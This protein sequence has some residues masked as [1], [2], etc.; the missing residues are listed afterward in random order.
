M[1]A[2]LALLSLATWVGCTQQRVARPSISISDSGPFSDLRLAGDSHFS[3]D[4]QRMVAVAHAYL[5]KSRGKPLDARYQI[6][7]T[8]DGYE[9]F[10]MY[11]A[12]YENARPLF[13]PGGHGIV[14]LSAD[15][16]V[17]RYMPGE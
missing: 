10:V 6:E 1:R 11:V 12:G 7:R 8:K 14:V 17:I 5:E 15:G 16:T 4:E 13:Y 3:T 9:V 2:L